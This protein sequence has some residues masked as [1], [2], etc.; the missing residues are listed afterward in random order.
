MKT[1]PYTKNYGQIQKNRRGGHP[2]RN[3]KL[4]V[5][6]QMVISEKIHTNN[7]VLTHVTFKNMYIY[8]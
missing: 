1:H 4:I 8:T 5:Q 2:Q 6:S 7:N 3:I